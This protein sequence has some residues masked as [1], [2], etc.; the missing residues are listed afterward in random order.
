MLCDTTSISLTDEQL[1]TVHATFTNCA[2][3]VCFVLIV[4]CRIYV[5]I[6]AHQEVISNITVT[7]TLKRYAPVSGFYRCHAVGI[8]IIPILVDT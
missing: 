8:A 2:A 5:P 4:P 6:H 1:F 3:N 7:Y